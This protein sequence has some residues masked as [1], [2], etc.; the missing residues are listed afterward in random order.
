MREKILVG[1]VINVGLRGSCEGKGQF[2]VLV[3]GKFPL[4]YFQRRDKTCE[5]EQP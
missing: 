1:V 3:N 2:E 4:S 5:R